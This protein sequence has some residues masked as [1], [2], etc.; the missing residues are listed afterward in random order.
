[1]SVGMPSIS[2]P[3]RTSVQYIPLG[4]NPSRAD[5]AKARL[6]DAPTSGGR[7]SPTSCIRPYQPCPSSRAPK[8]ESPGTKLQL[9]ATA[10]AEDAPRF[11]STFAQRDLQLLGLRR[12]CRKSAPLDLTRYPPL[13]DPTMGR[14]GQTH[15]RV[16]LMVPRASIALPEICPPT[17]C[18]GRRTAPGLRPSRSLPLPA[19]DCAHGVLHGDLLT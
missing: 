17:M 4:S 18:H 5:D 11:P 3:G 1:M 7:E 15:G 9:S 12:C 19:S 8:P 16:F 2:G 10:G 6:Q 13:I 14:S